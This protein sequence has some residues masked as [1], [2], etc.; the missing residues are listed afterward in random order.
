MQKT[1]QS[2]QSKVFVSRYKKLL[3]LG[4]RRIEGRQDPARQRCDEEIAQTT[5]VI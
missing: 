5:G 1:A 4:E 2:E 3:I